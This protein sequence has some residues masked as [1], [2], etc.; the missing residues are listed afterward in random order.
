MVPLVAM[1][2]S[3][4]Y[5]TPALL[6]TRR[7]PTQSFASERRCA[8]M[9][10]SPPSADSL[11][12]APSWQPGKKQLLGAHETSVVVANQYRAQFCIGD[13]PMARF[14]L[15]FAERK[16]GRELVFCKVAQ[17]IVQRS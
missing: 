12:C 10:V 3:V 2:Q 8:Q 16:H 4:E 15:S 5:L 7:W 17:L 11:M 13:E 14:Q 6:F 9:K 1:V